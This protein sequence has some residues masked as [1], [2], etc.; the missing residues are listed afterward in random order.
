MSSLKTKLSCCVWLVALLIAIFPFA[1]SILYAMPCKDDYVMASFLV[2]TNNLLL[3][4]IASTNYFYYTWNGMWPFLFVEFFFNPLNFAPAYSSLTGIEILLM[5]LAFVII[6]YFYIREILRFFF[7]CNERRYCCALY[8]CS[9]IA[10]LNVDFYRQIF[11]WFVGCAAYL[12]SI[13]FVMLSQICAMRYF[14]K[15]SFARG[16][17]L[18]L[19]GF[20]GCFCYQLGIFMGIFYLMC[21]FRK[22]VNDRTTVIKDLIPLIFMVSGGL[23]SLLAPGNFCRYNSLEEHEDFV[24]LLAVTIR[25]TGRCIGNV[26]SSPLYLVFVACGIYL[27]YRMHKSF[28]RAKTMCLYLLVSLFGVLFP[29]A[30]G[31]PD[32]TVANRIKFLTN[33]VIIIWSVFISID[34]G[35]YIK[36]K[37]KVGMAVSL[38]LLSLVILS[39]SGIYGRRYENIPWVYTLSHMRI[40]QN[41]KHYYASV[42]KKIYTSSDQDV[43]ITLP[44][45]HI[46]SELLITPLDMYPDSDELTRYSCKVI[47]KKSIRVMDY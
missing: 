43:V 21:M 25:N 37:V 31:Y 9:V 5:F 41:E 2:D 35:V 23:F 11:Y 6:L 44:D 45:E 22:P 33:F 1:L 18:A 36:N 34:V 26:M 13:V 46:G 42:L 3:D 16:L 24:S 20:I 47:G 30:I 19:T 12:L 32:G 4:S 38:A 7:D 8:L 10:F 14:G 15:R 27:G 39:I 17:V 28:Q 29:L 40:L